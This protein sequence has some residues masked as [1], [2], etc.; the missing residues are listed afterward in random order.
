M[1]R[2]AHLSD[3]HLVEPDHAARR[4]A[5]WWR[6]HYL[7]FK[8]P[9]DAAGRYARA[10]RALAQAHASGADHLVLTGDLTED[11][12][13][14]QF[15]LLAE[16]LSAS[17][18]AAEQVTLVPG[19]HDMYG[20]GAWDRAL[21]GSLAPWAPTSRGLIDLAE[22]VIVPVSTAVEQAWTRSSGFLDFDALP[23]LGR[24]LDQAAG[25]AIVLALHHPPFRVFHHWIHGLANHLD[26]QAFLGENPALHCLHGHIHKAVDRRVGQGD[27]RVFSVEAVA[28]SADPLRVY[29]ALGGR[30]VPAA[31]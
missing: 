21:D 18:F 2:I 30:V 26:L 8:R 24:L 23:D 7:S 20:G 4:G 5:D 17:G 9:I 25:R 1:T 29:T 28:E 27:A 3:F 16:L 10:E 6:L 19:N 31:S 12:R 22:A 15:A 11:S 13:T 14:S